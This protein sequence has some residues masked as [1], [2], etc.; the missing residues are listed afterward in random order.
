MITP[1]QLKYLDYYVRENH[2]EY[3]ILKHIYDRIP[4]N[5][6]EYSDTRC[7]YQNIIL[8][9]RLKKMTFK[10]ADIVI[11]GIKQTK[12]YKLKTSFD[13]LDDILK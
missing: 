9:D 4:M 8:L 3:P 1:Q 11:K 7:N 5:N 10:Q 12:H 2:R 6:E 13:I